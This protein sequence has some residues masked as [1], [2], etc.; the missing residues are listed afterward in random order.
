[1]VARTT[2]SRRSTNL[3]AKAARAKAARTS[4]EHLLHLGQLL[5]TNQ[6]PSTFSFVDLLLRWIS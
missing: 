6:R 1:M 5:M 4:A 2:V 3:E